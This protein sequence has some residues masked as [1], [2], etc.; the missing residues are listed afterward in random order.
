MTGIPASAYVVGLDGPRVLVPARVAAWLDRAVDLRRLR[1][2][3]RGIDPEVDAVLLAFAVIAADW[4]T[5]ATGTPLRQD[6]APAPR[7]YSTTR[8]ADRLHLAPRTVRLACQSGALP[9]EQI[10]GR[11]RIAAEDVE[12]YAAARQQRAA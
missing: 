8:A 7:W 6:P 5:A 10:D 1:T 3:V 12:Q 11:W 2:S 4:R 9:A